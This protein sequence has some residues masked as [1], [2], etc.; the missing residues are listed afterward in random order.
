MSKTFEQGRAEVTALCDYFTKNRDAFLAP[1]VKE[2][3]VRQSLI[4]PFFEA[5]G[6]NVSNNPPVA[7]Q[8]REVI[9]EDSLDVEGHQKAPDYTFRVGTLPKFYAEAKKCGVNINADP[10]P[11][12]QLRR[13]GWSAKVPVS[14]LT[15]FEELAL[16]DCTIRP[17]PSDKAGYARTE[18]LR[19]DQYPDQW[20]SLWDTYSREAVWSG[21]FDQ[22]AASKR[23]R[24][25][26]EVDEEF[27]REIEGWRDDLAR[28][29]ALRN[30][31]LSSDDLNRAVQLT[32]D[33]VVFLRM[34]EDKGLET[35]GQLLRLCEQPGIY[36]R[37][38]AEL[39]RK[40]D[41]KYNSG[42]FHFQKEQGVSEEPD[43]ITPRLA[44]DDKVFKP[45]LQSL[46]FEHGSPYRFDL[47]PV[48]ILGTV[49]ER[50]L[51][52]VIR[53]TAGHQAKVEE[54]PEVRKAGGVYYTPGYIVDYI[55]QQT[56]A[57]QI[58]GKSPAQLAG[59]TVPFSRR[60]GGTVP[61]SRRLRKGD[62]PLPQQQGQQQGQSPFSEKTPKMGTVPTF[63]VLDMACGSGSFLLG[64]YRCILDHALNWYV[65]HDL[66]NQKKAV[67]RDERGAWRLTIQEKKR[68]LTTHIFGVDIDSQAV[69]VSKLSLL[70][71][72]L[73][74][75]TDRTVGQTM[76]LFHERALPN[77]AANIKC[78]NSLIGPDYF[79]GRLIPESE[80]LARVNAF[81]WQREFP[82]AVAA[83]GFDCVIGNPPY[84]RI[85]T[86]KEWAPLEVDTYKELYRSAR[87]GNYDIYV[88]FVE[89]GLQLLNNNGLLGFILPGKFFA[90]D[91][92]ASLRGVIAERKALSQIVDFGASQVFDNATTYTC[93]LFLTG[94]PTP[95]FTYAKVAVPSTLASVPVQERTILS[96]SVTSSPWSF[97]TGSETNIVSK[98]SCGSKPLG[99][100]PARIGR[101]SSTGNDDV[102]MLIRDGKRFL[103]RQGE[104]VE[105]EEEALRIP[106]YATDYNR[107]VF[108]P[109]SGEVVIFPYDVS[110]SG[111]KLKAE[112]VFKREFPKAHLYL[113]SRRKALETRKQFKDWYGYSAPRNLE[114][115]D[116]A[117]LL[118]PL[119]ADK[120]SFC[121]LPDRADRFCLMASGGFSITVAATSGLSP[122]YVL[123]LMNS[124]LLFWRLRSISNIF[125]AGWITCTK[126]YV[127]TLPI[128]AVEAG[129]QA[130]RVMHDRITALVE[131][132]LSLHERLTSANSEPQR[133]V[134][135]RQIDS[136]DAE[137]D[138]LVYDLYGLT[139]EEI[140]IVEAATSR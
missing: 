60:L 54:K 63:R 36:A 43:R 114:V 5:L 117:E 14:I 76:R 96:D 111:Y 13:Y 136:T 66:E 17:R 45:I 12:Y 55:V 131:A 99:E 132:M 119:L 41:E 22:F 109:K 73:E 67:Y 62:C 31:R 49:Y 26:S 106:I 124:K 11:A 34:A 8:Y 137:I 68:L 140:A 85:Q 94:K 88:V 74:G 78:G 115:H 29:I 65:E 89:R 90:T 71:K 30:P 100:I 81:D 47:L 108:N 24:G 130:Q 110:A 123:G 39:G 134:I 1:G 38:M 113:A 83:G 122:N 40:A 97:S 102:F 37:F 135:Q 70:L 25:T 18:Y 33:R 15:D 125:R 128:R 82:D 112:A 35:Y 118:V 80:E 9:P 77:L 91:Y 101:G 107:Y 48:E 84:I 57:R 61:F 10:V 127:E 16:Y 64:A 126:Q 42:L 7:P 116:S 3:H 98:L 52:K 53:L 46:Y 86:M 27:L 20:R 75:E 59:G 69:E 120:G 21:A 87:S 95:S 139:E 72:V 6:W 23:K 28:N 4:D 79:T 138:R 92:G 50:F 129:D 133:G 51:G 32:I 56:V 19:F 93:L 103:T 44:V 105:V 58:A 104:I 2:A 121:R